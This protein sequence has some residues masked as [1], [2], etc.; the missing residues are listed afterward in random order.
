MLGIGTSSH[1]PNSI[2]SFSYSDEERFAYVGELLGHSNWIT[3]LCYDENEKVLA[4]G[5][6]DC[7]VRLWKFMRTANATATA[8]NNEINDD[9]IVDNGDENVLLEDEEEG[10]PR[11]SCKNANA[12]L[13]ALLVGHEDTIAQIQWNACDKK[14]SLL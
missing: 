3:C 10:T 2:L 6:V 8:S 12:H 11:A 13:S 1:A 5:S 7:T 4:S 14:I 9:E